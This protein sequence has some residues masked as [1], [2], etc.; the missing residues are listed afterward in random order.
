MRHILLLICLIGCC[1]INSIAQE[2]A[3]F[4]FKE[5][6]GV[7]ISK[8]NLPLLTGKTW[9]TYKQ[10]YVNKEEGTAYSGSF[11]AFKFSPNGEFQGTSGNLRL[12]GTWKLE[13]KRM[14]NLAMND[15][16]EIDKEV[17][18]SGTYTIYKLTDGELVMV[19]KLPGDLNLRII[20]YCKSSKTSVL[21]ENPTTFVATG[22]VD[23]EAVEAI[24]QQREQI[25]LI[26]EIETEALLRG[27]KIKEKLEK[28]DV[29]T[30]QALKKQILAGAYMKTSN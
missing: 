15:Q 21:A 6:K 17:K 26:S 1:Q 18:V 19:K 12:S 3:S 23:K 4:Q 24:R 13:S 29:K 27:I 5:Q 30:L 28:L 22:A 9:T 2:L 16:N 10:Y 7:T 8:K 11:M 20:Y 14:L 25:N